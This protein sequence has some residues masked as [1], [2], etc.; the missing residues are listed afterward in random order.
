MAGAAAAGGGWSSRT[1]FVLAAVGAA[2]GLGNIWRFPTLA[3][4]NGGGAFVIIYIGFVILLGLPLVLSEISLGRAGGGDAIGS[5]EN[6]ATSSGRSAKWK[7]LGALQILAGFL[8]LSFYCVV[9][10]WVLNYV[11]LTFNDWFGALIAGDPF[12]VAFDG[13]SQSDITNRMGILFG[14]PVRMIIL[15][16]IF[17][18]ATVWI[19][20]SGV[21][22]GIEKAAGLLMPGFFFLLVILSIYGALTGNF[23]EA[24]AFLFTPDFSKLTPVVLNEALGQALFSLS[25]A[26]GG[27][28]TYGAYVGKEVDLGST[29]AMI[30]AA[31]TIV[32]I[33]AGLMIFPIAFAVGLDPAAGPA[34]IFQTLPVAFNSMPAGAFVGFVFF[35]L[36][37]FAA[38]TSS[39]SLL[40]GPTAWVIEKFGLGRRSA[41][42]LVGSVAFSIG[43]ACALG[44]NVLSD[45]RLLGFWSLFENADILDTIDGFTGKIMLPLG[46]LL[47][48]IFIGWRADQNLV[49]KEVG[50]SDNL[51]QVWRFLIAWLC[52][53]A[54]FLVLL[55][56]M[57]P[58]ILSS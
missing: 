18:T 40:E 27:L 42:V 8:I 5:V 10:G 55:F 6:V 37:S 22:H 48:S 56:G 35:L 19:V 14:D 32:A 17:M 46:A 4:E 52:P 24:V 16:A 23:L 2:V 44:Y 57:F 9:A 13:E 31:D 12:A 45:V 54:V 28:L 3:G 7:G 38:L 25:L 15:H 26:A 1:A 50:L 29:S 39:I 43:V 53:I 34:L 49:R 58:S 36:I 21:Q 33:L 11:F 20:A 51:F 47:V 30:A 41:S